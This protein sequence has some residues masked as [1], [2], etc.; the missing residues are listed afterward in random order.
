[1]MSSC[2]TCAL[3]RRLHRRSRGS[4][5]ATTTAGQSRV[6]ERNSECLERACVVGA[7]GWAAAN[8]GW[9]DGLEQQLQQQSAATRARIG[10]DTA[11]QL[12]C[13]RQVRQRIG[14]GQ[15]RPTSS[16]PGHWSALPESTTAT[17]PP[18]P[19]PVTVIR[20]ELDFVGFYMRYC[21]FLGCVRRIWL[22]LL[23]TVSSR[24]H[25]KRLNHVWVL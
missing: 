12:T 20:G 22:P 23:T 19:H 16:I 11:Q 6:F 2:K 5:A 7:P 25:K 14:Q 24:N 9:T 15:L 21:T 8:A 3:C 4:S 10:G 13:Q 17:V 1:M 18:L